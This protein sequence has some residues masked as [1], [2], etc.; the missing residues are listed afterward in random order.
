MLDPIRS[1][2]AEVMPTGGRVCDMF[3]GSGTVAAALAID[4]PVTAVDIQNYSTV[5]C[6]ALLK[7][8]MTNMPLLKDQIG[9]AVRKSLVS[10]LYSAALPLIELEERCTERAKLGDLEGLCEIIENG[11]IASVLRARSQDKLSGDLRAAMDYCTNKMTSLQLLEDRRSVAF[12]HFGGVYFSYRQA[13][14]LDIL[15]G[16]SEEIAGDAGN[17]IKAATLTTASEIVNTVGKQFAQPMRPRNKNG[18]IKP[19]LYSIV[20]RDRFKDAE[21]IFYR[22]VGK[23]QE[24]AVARLEHSVVRSDYATYLESSDFSASAV[25]ADPPYTRDHY[26]RFYHVLET[27]SLRD[28]PEI[29]SNKVRGSTHLSRGIYRSNRHQSPFCIRSRAPQAFENLFSPIAKKHIPLILSYSPYASEEDA[30]PRVMTMDAILQIAERHFKEVEVRS[31]GEF[32]HS[33]LNKTD[34]N[35]AIS[36]DAEYLFVCRP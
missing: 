21:M 34:L 36:R 31:V 3:A 29:T 18:E 2:L 11:S 7:P 16:V 28:N 4:R 1:A 9:N 35:K 22:S 5:I 15:L 19:S 10:G 12:S 17:V 23:Y 24:E 27:L 25:Y 26:S 8:T 30:H 32:A 33:R 14:C 6:S 20:Q 13:V